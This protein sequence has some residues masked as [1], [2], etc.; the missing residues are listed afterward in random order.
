MPNLINRINCR[1]TCRLT[2]AILALCMTLACINATAQD[3]VLVFSKTAGFRHAS[4]TDGIAMLQAQS[5]ANNFIVET[6]EDATAFNA[7]NLARFRAVVWLSTTGD[8]LNDAQQL[9]FQTWIEAGGGYVGVHGAADCEYNWPWYGAGILGAGAWFM[10]HPAIQT[11]TIIRESATDP[12]TAHLPSSYSFVD[13]WY[14]FR[15]NPRPEVTVLLR[16]DETSY[17]PGGGAM[18]ADHP[19]SWKRNVGLGR[20]WYTALGHRSQNYADSG[21]QQHVLGGLLWAM[22]TKELFANGFEP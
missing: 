16:I 19:I 6:S 2:G 7:A 11:A 15:V 17:N 3:R 8:V 9:A 18:G 10:N 13:E 5:I 20:S 22:G 14:N 21:F 4:I 1:F 12:S